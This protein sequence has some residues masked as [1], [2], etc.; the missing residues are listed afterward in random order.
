M[1]HS[2]RPSYHQPQHLPAT[3]HQQAFPT[4]NHPVPVSYNQQY[5]VPA[6]TNPTANSRFP[7]QQP[8]SRHLPG[9]MQASL[10]NH[11][12]ASSIANPQQVGA[13]SMQNQYPAS[14]AN[15]SNV[16]Y[17]QQNISQQQQQHIPNQPHLTSNQAVSSSMSQVG[18]QQHPTSAH[19]HSEQ[20]HFY[21]QSVHATQSH[22]QPVH[23][24]QSQMTRPTQ[25]IHKQIGHQ[26]QFTAPQPQH[27]T[28]MA[29][30]NQARPMM[31]S[32]QQPGI[33]P[34]QSQANHP[35]RFQQPTRPDEMHLAQARQNPSP[36]SSPKHM[37]THRNQ[38]VGQHTSSQP[39]N[40]P[41]HTQPPTSQVPEVDG[42]LASAPANSYQPRMHYSHA[43]RPRL[44]VQQG[45]QPPGV[46]QNNALRG[47]QP[48]ASQS[49]PFNQQNA[50]RNINPRPSQ[51]ATA[52]P[53]QLNIRPSTTPHNAPVNQQSLP[54]RHPQHHQNM[55]PVQQI[56]T[57]PVISQNNPITQQNNPR[58]IHH[59]TPQNPIH[60]N[61]MIRGQ[62]PMPQ[63]NPSNQQNLQRNYVPGAVQNPNQQSAM[64]GVGPNIP[65]NYL[66][67][68]QNVP[69]N[70]IPSSQPNMNPVQQNT[71]AVRPAV[72][73]AA[74]PNQQYAPRNYTPASATNN[75]QQQQPKTHL[76]QFSPRQ[77]FNP[78]PRQQTPIAHFPGKNVAN[79][80]VG[81]TNPQSMM[82]PVHPQSSHQGVNPSPY[83][84]A[85]PSSQPLPS[86]Q[87]VNPL[88]HP[89]Q[90]PYPLSSSTSSLLTP[91]VVG[92]QP[93]PPPATIAVEKKPSSDLAGL[94]YNSHAILPPIR[95]SADRP[96]SVSST[97]A[98][99]ILN[100]SPV[101]D[102]SDG[103]QTVLKPAN[104]SW[105][106]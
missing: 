67:R 45:F 75:I 25:P 39:F 38:P 24:N 18:N 69:R 74:P 102:Y 77:Q 76:G 15:Q 81:V 105:C 4:N 30:S 56:G 83:R 80:Q 32:Q 91:T 85:A 58:N 52:N 79:Q 1:Q 61:A 57:R 90:N 65:Q 6:S 55:N 93:T 10:E 28:Q 35:Q 73:H 100:T 99:D 29:Y 37:P 46:V 50:Q 34:G 92:K 82:R 3:S 68:G 41:Q 20:Q 48:A 60:Q 104:V 42:N 23:F 19:P 84:T 101:P 86:H 7:N 51:N 54:Y 11:Q 78:A 13:S 98:D 40:Q 66:V 9:Q 5:H 31:T 8:T 94:T 62:M 71:A 22:Q 96:A 17:N 59:G 26:S 16:Q 49:V 36:Y 70:P 33:I 27:S 95:T 64:V 2:S 12:L 89:H 53:P 106:Y 47:V 14:T 103:G 72:P 97:S 63:N 88:D 87:N 44:P 43:P 21:Q